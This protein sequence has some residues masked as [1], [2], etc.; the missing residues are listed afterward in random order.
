[1]RNCAFRRKRGGE[2][3]WWAAATVARGRNCVAAGVTTAATGSG[4]GAV[5]AEVASVVAGGIGRPSVGASE[6][7]D[8]Q[9]GIAACIDGSAAAVQH[10]PPHAGR[11]AAAK[12]IS[13]VSRTRFA[14]RV[15]VKMPLTY[16][17]ATQWPGAPFPRYSVIA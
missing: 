10:N 11:T 15:V 14:D 13:A 1:M 8:A 12:T 3:S 5:D 7:S 2:G 17:V 9:H 4:A 16:S 6:D